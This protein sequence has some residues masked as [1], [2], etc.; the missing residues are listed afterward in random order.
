ML[1]KSPLQENNLHNYITLPKEH[2]G[3]FL[4]AL[5]YS[6]VAYV[7]ESVHALIHVYVHKI[8]IHQ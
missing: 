8:T 3:T 1:S 6:G 5:L 4:L 7:V 2:I